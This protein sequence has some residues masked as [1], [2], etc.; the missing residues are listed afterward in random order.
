MGG[1]GKKRI[2]RAM[3]ASSMHENRHRLSRTLA[4]LGLISICLLGQGLLESNEAGKLG[5]ALQQVD[6]SWNPSDWYLNQ[7]QSYQWL[8]QQI[9]GQPLRLWGPSIGAIVIRLIGYTAWSLAI[10]D[11][12]ILLGLSIPSTLGAVAIFLTHQSLIAGEWMLGGAE[13]KTFAYAALLLAFAAWQKKKWWIF[14]LMSGIACTFHILVGGYGTATL[15]VASIIGTPAAA[16]K[17][18]SRVCAGLT[19]GILPAAITLGSKHEALLQG[20]RTAE[21]IPSVTWIYT[22]LRNPHHLAPSSWDRGEWLM[23]SIWLILFVLAVLWG[24]RDHSTSAQKRRSLCLWTALSLATFGLGLAISLWDTEGIFLR[25]YPFRLADT[26]APLSTSLLIAYH[27]EQL[28]PAASRIGSLLIATIIAIQL[29][30]SWPLHGADLFIPLHP[31]RSTQEEL[32]QWIAT[33]T[34]SH[35]R[36]LTPP[37][38]FEDMSLKTGRAAIAQ[39][40]QIPNRSSDVQ[41]W[42]ERMQ[43]MGGDTAFWKSSKG[44]KSRRKLNSGYNRL[45][46]VELAEL[47]HQYQADII[48]TTKKQ[49]KPRNWSLAFRND[50]WNA[51]ETAPGYSEG[52]V[53]REEGH[54]DAMPKP[55]SN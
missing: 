13:P 33:K 19:L 54:R 14:G 11:V 32:Y 36:I 52:S 48:V 42:F 44:L 25:F 4:L 37:G 21:E 39:F 47:A 30:G 18:L 49:A 20:H 45:T 43:A 35:S 16:Q 46:D 27:L 1:N 38:G 55:I 12:S 34:P 41:E 23:A 17:D 3:R 10:A 28:Q 53:D 50:D 26:L 15:L 24:L 7:P 22:Y 5:L 6:P 51:W 8:F 9:S 29:Y 2:H 31:G 40:K